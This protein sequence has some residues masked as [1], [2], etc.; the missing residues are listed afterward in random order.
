VRPRHYEFGTDLPPGWSIGWVGSRR[1]DTVRLRRRPAAVAGHSER[2]WVDD[3][4][5]DVR[6]AAS[7][8][9]FSYRRRRHRSPGAGRGADCSTVPVRLARVAE[10]RA[11]IA[12]VPLAPGDP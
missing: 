6:T 10:V 3:D 9:H 4:D 11:R 2:C 5:V 12:G 1:T 7:P 8:D